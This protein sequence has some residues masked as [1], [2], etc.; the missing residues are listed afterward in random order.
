MEVQSR[1]HEM[2]ICAH[3]TKTGSDEELMY[4]MY[5]ECVCVY[6]IMMSAGDDD[7]VNGGVWGV[8]VACVNDGDHTNIEC[9]SSLR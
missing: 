7:R 6:V 1:R 9:T 3:G 2:H 4:C 5:R 8:N